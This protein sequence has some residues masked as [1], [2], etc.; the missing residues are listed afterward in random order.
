ML[1]WAQLHKVLVQTMVSTYQNSIRLRFS[2]QTD[3]IYT[4]RHMP[5]CCHHARSQ[6]SGTQLHVISNSRRIIVVKELDVMTLCC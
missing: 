1:P 3:Q 6:C 5:C 2:V 4:R